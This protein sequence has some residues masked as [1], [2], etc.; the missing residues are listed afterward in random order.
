MSFLDKLK[1]FS[2]RGFL[3]SLVVRTK[4]FFFFLVRETNRRLNSRY[5]TNTL[6]CGLKEKMMVDILADKITEISIIIT[7]YRAVE[8]LLCCV[9]SLIRADDRAGVEVV[10]YGDG[11]HPEV[12]GILG[13]A[14]GKGI[15]IPNSQAISELKK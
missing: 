2:L 4:R 1:C 10:V 6:S 7:T 8:H 9:R 14:G 13:W 3:Y 15:A 5:S 12:K 11:G